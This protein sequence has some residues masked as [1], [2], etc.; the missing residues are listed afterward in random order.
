MFK[1]TYLTALATGD[2]VV[3]TGRL[4]TLRSYSRNTFTLSPCKVIQVTPFPYLTPFAAS[5]AVV[6]PRRLVA[7]NLAGDDS[8]GGGGALGRGGGVRHGIALVCGGKG[9]GDD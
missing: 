8:L 2:A 6:V 4:V 9:G 3:V 7:A 5:H 1:F